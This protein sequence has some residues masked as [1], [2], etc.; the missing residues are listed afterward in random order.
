MTHA[1]TI[2]PSHTRLASLL[3]GVVLPAMITTQSLLL[4]SS[5]TAEAQVSAPQALLGDNLNWAVDASPALSSSIAPSLPNAPSPMPQTKVERLFSLENLNDSGTQTAAHLAPLHMK[6]IPA[7]WTAQPITP[8]DKVLL[9]LKDLVSPLDALG[10]LTSAGY[11][12]ALKGEPNYGTDSGA[13]GETLGAAAIRETTEGIFT[14]TVFAPLLHEDPRYYV[15]GSKYGF[16]HRFAYAGTREIFTRTDAGHSSVNGAMIL[17]YAASSALSYT[18][19]P[20]INK[21][22]DDTAAT[23]GGSLGGA[24]IGFLVSEFSDSV[25][26][27]LHLEK[28]P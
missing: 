10:M 21:N 26:Q 7:G 20:K 24:A 12:F 13:F 14:D 23:M 17:G 18:Y 4:P 15:E 1:S 16:F 8:H 6:Y 9:G 19:Y 27:A 28:K 3:V 11:S 2:Q 25:L 5:A 22:F